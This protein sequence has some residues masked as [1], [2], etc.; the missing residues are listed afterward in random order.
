M[1]ILFSQVEPF[2]W[3]FGIAAISIFLAT[4]FTDTIKEKFKQGGISNRNN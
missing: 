4:N 1:E 3:F 2:I